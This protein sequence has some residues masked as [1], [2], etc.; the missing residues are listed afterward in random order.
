MLFLKQYACVASEYLVYSGT[1]N[2][3]LNMVSSY[4]TNSFTAFCGALTD[5][6]VPVSIRGR[7]KTKMEKCV[8]VSAHTRTLR[9]T[10]KGSPSGGEGRADSE[11]V[12]HVAVATQQGWDVAG[13]EPRR[14]EEERRKRGVR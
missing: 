7:K 6:Q 9:R 8:S 1:F 11:A 5:T 14:A 2:N 3:T 13:R 12:R 4:S 10:T